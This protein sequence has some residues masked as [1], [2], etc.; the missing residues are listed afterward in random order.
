[1]FGT[2]DLA[3]LLATGG[4]S[5]PRRDDGCHGVMCANVW[6]ASYLRVRIGR[7]G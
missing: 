5:A 6:M 2:C 7:T 1:M 4:G 3:G